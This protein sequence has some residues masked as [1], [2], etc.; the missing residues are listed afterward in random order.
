MIRFMRLSFAF[1]LCVKDIEC[2][3]CVYFTLPSALINVVTT[4]E[5][6]YHEDTDEAIRSL[7]LRSDSFD[8]VRT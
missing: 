4:F 2:R 7:F 6:V 8:F 5:P 1:F 3:V